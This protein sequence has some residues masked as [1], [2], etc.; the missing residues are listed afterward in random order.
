MRCRSLV[1]VAKISSPHALRYDLNH[2]DYVLYVK[3]PCRGGNIDSTVLECKDGIFVLK[4]LG[5]HVILFLVQ[6]G[7]TKD[8]TTC[9]IRKDLWTLMHTYASSNKEL[10]F[11]KQP[12]QNSGARVQS[13]LNSYLD[14]STFDGRNK[15]ETRSHDCIS[16]TTIAQDIN[17]YC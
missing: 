9:L 4:L 13:L 6:D 14:S 12:Q 15:M 2:A 8:Y 7:P 1:L 10:H 5:I 3:Q 11:L 17:F 16:C